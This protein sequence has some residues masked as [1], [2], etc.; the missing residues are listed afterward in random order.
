MAENRSQTDALIDA[1]QNVVRAG[2]DA[3]SR[4]AREVVD[5]GGD[6]ARKVRRTLKDTVD[7]T[8]G[9]RNRPRGASSPGSRRASA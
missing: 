5:A 6:A 4:V 1:A 8:L 9:D 2:I 3:G 7:T